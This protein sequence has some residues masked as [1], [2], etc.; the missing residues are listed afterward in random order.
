MKLNK[1]FLIKVLPAGRSWFILAAVG[2]FLTVFARGQWTVPVVESAV[3]QQFTYDDRLACQTAIEQVYW[4]NREWPEANADPKPALNEVLP[5]VAIAQ[6]VDVALAQSNALDILWQSPITGEMLQAEINRQAAQTNNP[7][8]LQELW[9]SLD[10]D[11]L[12][13]AEC[14]A[15]PVLAHSRAEVG[16]YVIVVGWENEPVIVGERNAVPAERRIVWRGVSERAGALR[17]PLIRR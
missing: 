5:P 12:L 9:A 10:H 4:Q 17:W 14:L 6:K 15:R 7:E 1:H 11:P 13:I 16:P 8:M 2:F 3:S